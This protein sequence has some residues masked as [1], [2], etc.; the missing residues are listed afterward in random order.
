MLAWV[1]AVVIC[2]SVC[3]YIRHTQVLFWNGC[4]DR[5]DFCIQVSLGLCY[6]VF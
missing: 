1:L 5:A 4:M 2:L 6:T 3:L